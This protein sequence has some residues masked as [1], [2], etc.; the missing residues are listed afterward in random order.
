MCLF[1]RH[2]IVDHNGQ[3]EPLD[4]G[5]GRCSE[6]LAKRRSTWRARLMLEAAEPNQ[7]VYF[8]T[9]TYNNE[10]LPFVKLQKH[11][12]FDDY[13]RGQFFKPYEVKVPRP[14]K[15]DV[16]N[17]FKRLRRHFDYRGYILKIRYF[18]V[19]EYGPTT[20]RPHYHAIIFVSGPGRMAFCS[21]VVRKTWGKGF[22]MVEKA[23]HNMKTANYVSSYIGIY[24]QNPYYTHR[25]DPYRF[26][27]DLFTL[28]DFDKDAR[29]S[30][31]T[32]YMFS[33]RLGC[34]YFCQHFLDILK[35]NLEIEKK[36]NANLRKLLNLI[37]IGEQ[38]EHLSTKKE[39]FEDT[40]LPLFDFVK[41]NISK[42]YELK[43]QK[44]ND[45]F[46][47]PFM[48]LPK[49]SDLELLLKYYFRCRFYV[50]NITCDDVTRQRRTESRKLKDREFHERLSRFEKKR[51]K[52]DK[53]D[54]QLL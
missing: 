36:S 43:L 54:P 10:N 16:Q 7:D 24:K 44:G 23:R 53:W 41:V 33:Q 34:N 5:C 51:K 35:N 38:I 28:V 49:D 50:T 6:C 52:F 45:S 46:T 9:L 8:V 40:L 26:E 3:C 12:T 4:V 32:F 47:V 39:Y 14:S 18:V 31:D 15:K 30:V 13:L 29:N 2:I 17:F 37:R 48:L 11:S 27:E 22:V 42:I 19:S 25:G 20:K 1:P 21:S